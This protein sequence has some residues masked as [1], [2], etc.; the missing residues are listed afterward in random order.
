MEPWPS[1]AQTAASLPGLRIGRYVR[2]CRLGSGGMSEVWKAW[3]IATGRWVALKQ[4]RG[5]PEDRRRFLREAKMI[6]SLKHPSIPALYEATDDHIALE[7]LPGRSLEI[8][9]PRNPESVARIVRDAALA[10]QYANEQGVLHRDLKPANLHLDRD[11]VYVLD[12]GLA[13]THQPDEMSWPGLAIGTPGYL[14]PEQAR[15]ETDLDARTDVY[16]LGAVLYFLLS[17]RAPVDGADIQE[18]LLRTATA[19]PEPLP[20]ELGRIAAKCLD[21]DRDLR[22]ATAAEVARAL[23]RWLTIRTWKR[24]AWRWMPFLAFA[25][26][27]GFA[28]RPEPPRFAPVAP[29]ATAP[30]EDEEAQLRSGDPERV[31]RA[32]RALERRDREPL[33]EALL[34][35]YRDRR[36][37]DAQGVLERAYREEPRGAYARWLGHWSWNSQD[38]QFWYSRERLTEKK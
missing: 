3:D 38:R 14:S 23:D 17:G 11:R 29:L 21:L 26:A 24:R 22:Y 16:G 36:T 20:G 12:F 31:E 18:V 32:V 1:E 33:T 30:R 7:F 27:A 15:G 35:Y 4:F 34:L 5:T 37:A 9:P 13:R 10:V 28:L 8:D 2:V 19:A 6:A 25:L